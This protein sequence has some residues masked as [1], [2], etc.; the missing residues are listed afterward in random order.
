ML[1]IIKPTVEKN[2]GLKIVEVGHHAYLGHESIL[3]VLLSKLISVSFSSIA[4]LKVAISCLVQFSKVKSSNHIECISPC[5]G[6]VYI[7]P[8]SPLPRGEFFQDFGEFPFWGSF[9]LY[10]IGEAFQRGV[11]KFFKILAEYTPLVIV[12]TTV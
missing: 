3:F 11:G 1:I 2:H 7:L 10:M 6:G 8:L 9:S 4:A 5:Q 12:C